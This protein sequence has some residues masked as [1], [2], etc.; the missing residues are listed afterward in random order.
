MQ[1]VNSPVSPTSM[2][3]GKIVQNAAQNATFF[4]RCCGVVRHS[5]AKRGIIGWTVTE[6]VSMATAESFPADLTAIYDE[7]AD[8]LASAPSPEQIAAFRLSDSAEQFI[9]DLLEANRT[10]GLTPTESAA[11]DDYTRIERLMQAIKVRAFAKLD[12][13]P[14]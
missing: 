1:P 9:S 2:Q 5:L 6:D 7:V 3:P 10:R 11:L 4:A 12:Q 13:S 14:R 8:F